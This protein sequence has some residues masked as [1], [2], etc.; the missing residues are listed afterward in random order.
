VAIAAMTTAPIKKIQKLLRDIFFPSIGM[1]EENHLRFWCSF[2]NA[3]Q[4]V[5]TASLWPHFSGQY[6]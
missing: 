5:F 3:S 2:P 6:T 4:R 1:D